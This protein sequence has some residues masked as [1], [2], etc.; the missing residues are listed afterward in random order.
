MSALTVARLTIK[1]P[2]KFKDYA[3]KA[4]QTMEDFG[5]KFLFR[6]KA[7]KNLTGGGGDHQV[8]VIYQFPSLETA[9]QWYASKAY[10]SL[11]ALRDEA[12]DIQIFSYELMG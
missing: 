9:D 2:E 8:T 6:G 12:A 11:I 4:P 10:Q 3:S 1:D 5:A 7:D